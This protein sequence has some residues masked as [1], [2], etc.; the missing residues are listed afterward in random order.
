[1]ARISAQETVSGQIDSRSVLIASITSNP[2]SELKFG[3]AVFSPIK[4]GASSSSKTD[5][6]HPCNESSTIN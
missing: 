2:L 6:S 1:M 5:A 3:F 4:F